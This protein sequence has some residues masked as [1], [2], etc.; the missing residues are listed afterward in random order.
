MTISIRRERR[1]KLASL[2]LGA[3]FAAGLALPAAAQEKVFRMPYFADIG[4]FD[5][6]NAFEVGGLGAVNGVYE[7]LVEYKPGTTEIVG[8]LAKSW[9]VSPDQLTYTFH[10]ADGVS[11]RCRRNRGDRRPKHGAG[12]SRGQKGTALEDPEI[13]KAVL[14]AMNPALWAE[15]AYGGYATPAQS[16]YQVVM[17]KPEKPIVFP[18]DMAAAKAII[19]KAGGLSLT[20][21]VPTDEA[22]NVGTAVDLIVALLAE[23]GVNATINV[24]PQGAIYGLGEDLAAAPGH[25]RHP[26]EPRRCASRKPGDRVLYRDRAAQLPQRL[27]SG[28]RCHRPG[29]RNQG[30]HRRAERALREGRPPLFQLGLLF[31]PLVDIEDVVVH[32]AG[33]VD[34][35]LR[36]V[37][38]PGNIDFATVRWAE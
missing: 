22:P 10:L 11:L 13:R 20:I 3:A 14:T 19:A 24:L 32:K 1:S 9:E 5:P 12:R 21:G 29:G 16:V 17:L 34:L 25:R 27:R 8:L 6:D 15:Q 26:D 36:P 35:G 2:L 23:I 38:P 33:L 30:R 4:S 37:F 31:I 7:G 28:G 18:D